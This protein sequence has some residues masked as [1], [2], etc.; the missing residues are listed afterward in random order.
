MSDSALIIRPY[1]PQDRT[2]VRTIS[3]A[4][5]MMGEPSSRFFDGDDLLADL[6]TRYHTD[7]EPQSSF[8]AESEGKVVGYVIGA[9][10]IRRAAQ[11]SLFKIVLPVLFKALVTGAFLRKKN[12][13]LLGQVIPFASSGGFGMPDFDREY[14]AT[15]HINVLNGYRKLG[16]GSA[17]MRAYLGL[18][19]SKGVRGVHMATM[20]NMA[21][22]FFAK[23]GFHLLF[24][25]R[26]PYFRH[27]T[28]L[29][30]PLLVYGKKLI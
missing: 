3:L 25:G 22:E 30:V 10:D 14:P 2:M 18:L 17:L 12:R 8:I 9:T 1:D 13:L 29:D 4:T 6:L 23:N 7:F 27:L 11:I 21:G 24:Q 26:R 28:G 20:S 5:A 15:L 19:S 16:A